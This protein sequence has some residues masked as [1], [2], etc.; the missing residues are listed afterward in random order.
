M[1]LPLRFDSTIPHQ[2]GQRAVIGFFSV[3][4]KHAAGGLAFFTV[5]GNALAAVATAW[6]ALVVIGTATIFAGSCAGH[7]VTPFIKTLATE[8]TEDTE[9]IK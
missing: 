4:C 1:G 9:K 5:I 8:D 7:E 2:I 3:C 6:A